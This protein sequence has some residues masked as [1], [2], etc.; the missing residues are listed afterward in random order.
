MLLEVIAG[1][2]TVKLVPAFSAQIALSSAAETWIVASAP[3]SVL[4]PIK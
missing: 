4:V 3:E 1:L 2:I